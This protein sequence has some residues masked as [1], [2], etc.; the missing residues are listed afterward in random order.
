MTETEYFHW[1][2]TDD[3]RICPRCTK[4][5]LPFHDASQSTSISSTCTSPVFLSLLHTSISIPD[6]SHRYDIIVA[7]ETWLSACILDQE[8]L[9]PGYSLACKDRNWHGGGV[10]IFIAAHIPFK[11]LHF[12][13]RELE[14]ILIESSLN[15]QLFTIG[16]FC[17]LPGAPAD[18][19]SN[20][21]TTFH[22]KTLPTWFYVVILI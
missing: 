11:L 16:G 21:Y 13:H 4:Q 8:L 22:H 1:G 2:Q 9:I 15:S 12:A 3:G 20:L 5:T 14:L 17:C 19:M 7:V 18:L 6:I 10:A